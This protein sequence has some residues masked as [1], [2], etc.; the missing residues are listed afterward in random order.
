[1]ANINTTNTFLVPVTAIKFAPSAKFYPLLQELMK[2]GDQTASATSNFLA[3]PKV[4][5]ILDKTS[6]FID[7]SAQSVQKKLDDGSVKN[8]KENI[9]KMALSVQTSLPND[10]A[11][12]RQLMKMLK[13]EELAV[14]LE[15]G[16]QRLEQLVSTDIPKATQQ[17]LLKSGVYVTADADDVSVVDGASGRTKM[18]RNYQQ[19]IQQSRKMA[20]KALDDGLKQAKIDPSDLE[21][22]RGDLQ[23]NFGT[24]L[25]S[26]Q[27][28]AKSDR[29]LSG[30]FE[31]VSGLTSEWQEAT[32]RL[33]STQSA[34]LFM[35]GASRFQARAAAIFSKDQLNWAGEIGNKFTKAFTE[36]DAA[37]ARLKS[38][39]LGDNVRNRLVQAIE[40][41]SDSLGGLDGIIAGALT[42]FKQKTGGIAKAGD[43]ISGD[44]LSTILLSLQNQA[45][46]ARKEAHESLIGLLARRSE[47]RNEALLK[48]EQVMCNLESQLGDDLSPED[49]AAIARGDGGTAKLFEP[50]AKRAAKE[51][52][53]Q[54]DAAEASV[55][56]QTII[57]VLKH[58]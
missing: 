43:D 30:I 52:E 10:N 18:V 23:Q 16:K 45:S 31:N 7:A 25:V 20:L 17:S 55:T 35:E 37:V 47:Y 58:V 50:I 56:D 8:S 44:K 40:V 38:I 36:G 53:K 46:S 29:T 14:L 26:L 9:Q 27:D 39:K 11:G 5:E 54:L 48:V 42:T 12:L 57:D 1:M 24:M 15:T 19:S 2:R 34:S 51:I 4:T 22:L 33:M 3:Q 6:Q 13:N 21:S 41:G 28:A 49:I 32:G